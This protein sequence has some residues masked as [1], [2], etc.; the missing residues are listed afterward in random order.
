MDF[1]SSSKY[2]AEF[3]LVLFIN[4]TVETLIVLFSCRPAVEENVPLRSEYLSPNSD[5]SSSTGKPKKKRAG[6][7]RRTDGHDYDTDYNSSG[8]ELDDNDF[9]R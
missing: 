3:C 9:D 5:V 7:P 6:R 8:D 2:F 1:T 4:S